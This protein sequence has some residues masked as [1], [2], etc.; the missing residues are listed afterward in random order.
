M[1]GGIT[2]MSHIVQAQRQSQVQLE[3]MRLLHQI[4]RAIGNRHDLDSIYQVVVNHVEKQ[5][6]A[7]FCLMASYNSETNTLCPRSV[8][9]NSKEL[10]EKLGIAVDTIV[11]ANGVHVEAAL[12]GKFVHN[13]NMAVT[14]GPI[15]AAM[16][17][18]GGLHSLVITPLMKGNAVLGIA[19]F[20]RKGID[21]FSNDEITFLDQLSE[22]VALA[23]AQ[24]ELLTEL[25]HA[26]QDLKE[27][28]DLVLQQERLHALAEMA[29]GIA[30]DINNAIS[31]AAL[32]A[33]SLIS[34]ET[35][36]TERGSKH[37]RIIQ[38]AID[39]V[40]NTVARMSRFARP[41]NDQVIEQSSDV[42]RS[43]IESIELTRVK[44][45]DIALRNGI[46]IKMNTDFHPDL[47]LLAVSETELREIITNLL[48]NAIDALPQGGEISMRTLPVRTKQGEQ[49]LIEVTDNG[50]GMNE[51]QRARCFEPFFTTK[52]ERGTGLGLAMVYGIVKRA[53]GQMEIQSTPDQGT[54]IQIILPALKPFAK[55][56][57]TNEIDNPNSV[58]SPLKILLVDDDANVLTA[59][60]DILKDVGHQIEFANS[61]AHAIEI[62][63]MANQRL[64]PFDAVITDLG[65]P[66]MD[67]R[68]LST[69]IKTMRPET[70]VIML[71]GWGQQMK[72]PD[73]ELPHV[74]ALFSKPQNPKSFNTP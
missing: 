48:F 45:D 13:A 50:I 5:L 41:E 37:L 30:H 43:C 11:P 6:P 71:T 40:A 31:P 2:N 47:P 68:E 36:L 20:A 69:L 1:V 49:V 4:T 23:L 56:T 8:G 64:Q 3:Q 74:D 58:Q 10:A 46:E 22:H 51:T 61:G 55:L 32:Y 25:Q 19:V 62:F 27:T 54:A 17:A 39:D 24:T 9:E 66:G 59:L 12:K 60:T 65:M 53:G 7:D 21:A 14:R 72:L 35:N 28:Q 34:T 44:W 15:G 57:A 42:N 70:P 63:T 26:Y 38:T 29:S 73:S 33:E 67:G 18:V 52:G 16:H